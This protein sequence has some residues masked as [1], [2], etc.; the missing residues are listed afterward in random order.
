MSKTNGWFAAICLAIASTAAVADVHELKK[1][2]E[3][4]ES[5]G[6]TP[7]TTDQ[8]AG[9]K[10][11]NG[12]PATGVD[13]RKNVSFRGRVLLPDGKPAVN[14][15]LY[16]P[17]LP[18][19]NSESPDNSELVKRAITND[20][21]RFKF[22]ILA[23]EFSPTAWR[24]PLIAFK[25]GF[26]LAWFDIAPGEANIE[27]TL[28]LI[29][30]QPLR[31]RV[32]DNAGRPVA[33][34][35]ITVNGVWASSSDK[36]DDFFTAWKR[37][38]GTAWQKLDRQLYAPLESAI[39]A[40]TDPEGRFELSGVGI[41]RI[42]SLRITAPGF[43]SAEL[44]VVNRNGFDADEENEAALAS[45]DPQLR[46][47]DVIPRF[48]SPSFTHVAEAE[49][50]IRGQVFTGTNRTP[51]PDAVVSS[52][53]GYFGVSAWAKTDEAGRY[54]LHGLPRN[55][56]MFVNIGPPAA[57]NLLDRDLAFSEKPG[58]AVVDLDIELKPGVVVEGRVFDS[59]TG[60]GVRSQVRFVPLPG[61]RFVDQPGYD[62]YKF[63]P[64]AYGTGTDHEGK[65]RL[66]I[67]PGP[68]VLMAHALLSGDGPRVGDQEIIPYREA[69]FT[70]EES[71]RIKVTEDA[72]GRHFKTSGGVSEM[73]SLQ[74]ALKFI[75]A[76]LEDRETTCELSVNRGKAV[77]MN[78][79]DDKGR[80]VTNV[81]VAGATESWPT[82]FQVAESSCTIYA[83]GAD[84]P[85]RVCLLHP[86]RRLATALTLTGEEPQSVT[87]RLAA[88]ASVSGRAIDADGVPF[89]DAVVQLSYA[90]NNVKDLERILSV[91]R[92]AVKTDAEGRFKWDNI[93][94]GERFSLD[95]KKGD[96]YFHANLPEEQQRLNAG[97]QL[98]L[99]GLKVERFR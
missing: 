5:S 62:G 84:R 16:W 55:Q 66:T 7:A 98:N 74:N 32:T 10:S 80:P 8:I 22:S 64:E 12:Q 30:D 76:S 25:S 86:E 93:I 44:K 69:G 34:A 90:Q 41:E 67:V 38:W 14:A 23:A 63:N 51:V 1:E 75:S 77:E 9:P 15:E 82:T 52:S 37:N 20:D 79:E 31:G 56:G 96:A 81:F 13:G 59:T 6:N 3:T 97:Q 26:G 48:T 61:N 57:G 36:L 47:A 19:P 83:L 88:S 28:Q 71:K 78:I 53:A 18:S 43:A 46:G 11:P 35:R 40:V 60:K 29:E 42:A 49:L 99:G 72:N 27:A 85:R 94:P 39:G 21:G 17:H 91:E 4:P 33:Q 73:L 54:E 87:V 50:T 45:A 65:F 24:V 68:G 92:P 58:E 70:T 2:K 95:F 89:A